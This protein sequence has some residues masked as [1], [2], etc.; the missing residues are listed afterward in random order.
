MKHTPGYISGHLANQRQHKVYQETSTCPW[1]LRVQRGQKINITL[2]DYGSLE[3]DK[4]T[5]C[6]KYATVNEVSRE[7]RTIV[8]GGDIRVKN[9]YQSTSHE[10]ELYLT[11]SDHQVKNHFLLRYE[12]KLPYPIFHFIYVSSNYF[13]SGED[14]L[15]ILP[16]LSVCLPVKLHDNLRIQCATLQFMFGSL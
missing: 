6:R 4:R 9:V 3:H 7:S 12:G 14:I 1:I 10:I 8:C 15:M 5:L 13:F 2:L 11:P 16:C